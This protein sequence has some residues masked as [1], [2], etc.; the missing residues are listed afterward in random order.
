[1][2]GDGLVR[3]RYSLTFPSDREGKVIFF[4]AKTAAAVLLPARLVD[5]IEQGILDAGEARQLVELGLLVPDL[6]QERRKILNF[7]R[8]LEAQAEALRLIVVTAQACNLA[9]S[10]CYQGPEKGVARLSPAAS[11]HLV[12]FATEAVF[13]QNRDLKVTFYGGEPLL[14]LDRIMPLAEKLQQAAAARGRTFTFSFITNG[15]L[16]TRKAASELRP[17]GL[18]SALVTLDGPAAIHNRQRPLHNGGESFQRVIGN[19]QETWD[20]VDLQINANYS[21]EVYREYPRLLDDLLAA[22]LGP[23]RIGA[24]SFSPITWES[25]SPTF[26]GGCR[27]GNE[28][29]LFAAAPFLRE[30][31]LRRGYRTDRIRPTVCMVDL[32]HELVVDCDGSL[33]KCPCF[34]GEERFRVGHLATGVQDRVAAY[35]WD[36][37]RNAKCL[38]C[39]YLPLCFGGCR[40]QIFQTKGTAAALE[41]RRPFFDACLATFVTQDLEYEL[42]GA[43]SGTAPGPL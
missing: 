7:I 38:A 43:A 9:C 3:S 11:A 24:V 36:R 42:A 25:R 20:L 40:Y 30:E 13:E 16:L 10:Y 17:L 15:T 31:T 18:R 21:R 4:S 6:E 12:R 37:W 41:C 14:A 1:M 8:D 35:G 2:S 32:A 26:A 28:P 5:G 39:R 19:L 29:W 23:E 22:G 27:T 34:I 33:Y